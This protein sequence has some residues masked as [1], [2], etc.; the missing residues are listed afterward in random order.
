[1]SKSKQSSYEGGANLEQRMKI[2]IE[3]KKNI[4]PSVDNEM[5][6]E[7]YK[8]KILSIVVFMIGMSLIEFA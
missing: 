5:A 4:T 8:P 7:K 1:M 6:K 2:E 3:S